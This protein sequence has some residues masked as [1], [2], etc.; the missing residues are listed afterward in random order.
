[1]LLEREAEL[2]LITDAV[3]GARDGRPRVVTVTGPLGIGRSALLSEAARRCGS[4]ALVLRAGAARVEQAFPF[5]VVRQLADCA[6]PGARPPMPRD[7]DELRTTL[8][9]RAGGRPLLLLVDDLHWADEPSLRWLE[10]L[11]E[12][13][14]PAVLVVTGRAGAPGL[15]GKI[16]AHADHELPLRPLSGAAVET[17]VAHWFGEPGDAAFGE[18]CR[19]ISRGRPLVLTALLQESRA[20]RRRPGASA[21]RALRAFRPPV[22]GT[23]AVQALAAEAPGTRELARVLAVL[24]GPADRAL[25]TELTGLDPAER[26]TAVAALVSAGLVEDPAVPVFVHPGIR[27]AVEA[28]MPAAEAADRH[29]R[30]ARVLSDAGRPPKDVVRHLLAVDDPPGDW[31]VGVLRAAG[32]TARRR[33]DLPL[34]RRCLVRALVGVPS[35][36]RERAELLVELATVERSSAP[37]ASLRYLTRA[38]PRLASPGRRAR[39]LADVPTLMLEPA[40]EP[41]ARELAQ[42]SAAVGGDLAVALEARL[43]YARITD[44]T[45]VTDSLEAFRRLGPHPA[46]RAGPHRELLSVLAYTATLAGRDAE[47]VAAV[48][49]RV[50]LAAPPSPADLRT[51]V[52]LAARALLAAGLLNQA[53]SWLASLTVLARRQ[54]GDRAAETLIAESERAFSL[55]CRGWHAEAAALASRLLDRCDPAFAPVTTRCCETLA[56]VVAEAVAPD[57]AGRALRRYRAL[58]QALIPGW[59]GHLVDGV[60]ASADGHPEAALGHLLDCGREHD[61]MGWANPAV[62]PWRTWAARLQHRLGRTRLARE[63]IEQEL[64]LAEEWGTAP[65]L[66]RALRVRA[67]L[68]DGPEG[69]ELARRAIDVLEGSSGVLE[70]AKAHLLLGRRLLPDDRVEAA[71]HLGRGERLA[72]LCGV[73]SVDQAESSGPDAAELTPAERRIA[74]RVLEGG[75]NQ[76]IADD[77]DISV[78][79]VEK[80]LTKVYRKLGVPGRSGLSTVAHLLGAQD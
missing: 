80:H 34:A 73:E 30:A 61:L 58:E 52:P 75:A 13:P 55:A 42:A 10:L 59:L 18:A 20:T 62:L 54:W 37:V 66:G 32:R 57:V 5:G 44:I 79:A 76:Q 8:Y 74:R 14:G 41:L 45:H 65:C 33:G 6:P 70:L 2:S 12:S 67:S 11:V 49:R 71:G 72:K 1:V 53:D 31:A 77:L 68:T 48:A 50:V 26:D 36:G 23:R 60:L 21:V 4:G 9:E 3:D 35:G 15:A 64:G 38:L 56:L 51:G 22:L 16:F 7:D 46:V 63:L 17:L 29:L 78:R 24:D 43:R 40:P 39:E 28:A 69:T 27:E 25:L 47:K 19:T